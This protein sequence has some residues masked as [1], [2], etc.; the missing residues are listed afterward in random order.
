MNLIANP[1]GVLR[2]GGLGVAGS[3]PAAPT[4]FPTA[5]QPLREAPAERRYLDEPGKV[6]IR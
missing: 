1:L 2:S 3:N 5:P 4:K 6:A